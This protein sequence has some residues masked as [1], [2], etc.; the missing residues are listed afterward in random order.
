MTVGGAWGRPAA[1]V[2]A[3]LAVLLTA[4][5]PPAAPAPAPPPPTAAPRPSQVVVA[6]DDLG[7]GFNPH[8]LAH[9]SPVTTALAGLVLPS[10]FRPDADGGAAAR[11]DGRH[12]RP[13]DRRRTRSRSPTS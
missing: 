12:Q 2:V 11:P 8:L 3:L 4:C 5:T 13:G 10:V 7:A 1:L 9:Q 6:V